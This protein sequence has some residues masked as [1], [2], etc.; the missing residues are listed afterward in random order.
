MIKRKWFLFLTMVIV[1]IASIVIAA[2]YWLKSARYVVTENAFVK[3]DIAK[4]TAEV[5]GKTIEV[6]VQAHTKVNKGDVLIKIDP[7]PFKYTLARAQAELE[8]ARQQVKILRETLVEAEVEFTEAQDRYNYFRKRYERQID[9][10]KRGIVAATRSDELENDADTAKDR[11]VMAR[12][13]INR[14]RAS[15]GGT[16]K[17][18]ID[19]HPMVRA[20]LVAVDQA[21]LDLERTI[22][23]APV[24][25]T[26][27]A[28]PLVSGEQVTASQPLFAIVTDTTPWVDAN[29]KETQLTNVKVG[30]KA[31]IELDIYPDVR[32]QA[33]VT[34]ISPAT[35]AQ[36]A[37]LPPQNA[38]GNWVKV[39]QRLPVRLQ[40][41]LRPGMPQ[42]RAGMT[43]Q[44]AI[45]TEKE[46]LLGDLLGNLNAVAMMQSVLSR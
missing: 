16:S 37:I 35:G 5:S 27:A 2:N 9:L 3:I 32:W 11:V 20:K 6:R 19:D 39:V 8:I 31:T 15:L 22:V 13:K 17:Q 30:Q 44:V 34:S 46:R 1:P 43:A 41:K 23:K 26:I 36:F 24:S 28:V 7:R 45:D 29:F 18:P 42:L 14:V 33:R 12:Q 38:S 40:L 10:T 21:L 25:G 4:I